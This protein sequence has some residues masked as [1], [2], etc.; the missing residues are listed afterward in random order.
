MESL[1]QTERSRVI[2]DL[3]DF[4]RLVNDAAKNGQLD[5]KFEHELSVLNDGFQSYL[6]TEAEDEEIVDLWMESVG[7]FIEMRAAEDDTRVSRAW[8]KDA[9]DGLV[10]PA[11]WQLDKLLCGEDTD[12]IL[13]TA[14]NLIGELLRTAP[15]ISVSFDRID[16][17][18]EGV[19]MMVD[20]DG[21]ICDAES[22]AFKRPYGYSDVEGRFA[23]ITDLWHDSPDDPLAERVEYTDRIHLGQ[24]GGVIHP[25]VLDDD[26]SQILIDNSS[27]MLDLAAQGRLT[28]NLKAQNKFR[29]PV[30][31]AAE[32][33]EDYTSDAETLR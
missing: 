18:L 19:G 8:E 12:Y 13:P 25:C 21:F 4:M 32:I 15:V 2:E 23:P 17:M 3:L 11:L 9:P 10:T 33:Y 6:E 31:T 30:F 16:F 5:G 14:G 24:F 27:H 26:S 28:D 29:T 1:S 7:E 20:D 22:G